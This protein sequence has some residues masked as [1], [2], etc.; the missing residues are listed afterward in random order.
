MLFQDF[1]KIFAYVGTRTFRKTRLERSKT[2]AS[3]RKKS[4]L[5]SPRKARARSTLRQVISIFERFDIRTSS[6]VTDFPKRRLA[7]NNPKK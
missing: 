7:S 1:L 6:H 2:S 5:D 3:V 4:K